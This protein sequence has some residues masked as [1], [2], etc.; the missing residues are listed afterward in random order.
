MG[1]AHVQAE[2]LHHVDPEVG[3]LAVAEGDDLVPRGQRVGERAL[4]AAGARAGEDEGGA[5]GGLE[6]H[7]GV[8]QD[9]LEEGREPGVPVVLA[10]PVHRAQHVLVDVHGACMHAGT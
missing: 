4:P 3:E 9:G 5:L 10:R 7:L 6:D 1:R 8:L 2:P